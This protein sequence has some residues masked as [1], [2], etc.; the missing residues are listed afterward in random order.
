MHRDRT[1]RTP[2][3]VPGAASPI[4]GYAGLRQD[5]F[6]QAYRIGGAH[7]EDRDDLP[8]PSRLIL[9]L[10]RDVGQAELVGPDEE[11]ICKQRFHGTLPLLVRFSLVGLL[12]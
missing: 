3:Q 9:I 10:N 5:R 8:I 4:H 2:T 11:G 1:T 7:D 6:G 12:E